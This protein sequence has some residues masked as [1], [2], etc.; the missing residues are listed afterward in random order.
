MEL[1]EELPANA[2]KIMVLVMVIM[3]L[4]TIV[5]VVTGGDDDRHVSGGLLI[6]SM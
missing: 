6:L 2:N 4:V 3:V 1:E 5:L